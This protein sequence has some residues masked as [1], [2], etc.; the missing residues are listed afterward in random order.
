LPY[1]TDIDTVRKIVKNVGQA[2]MEDEEFGPDL[3][4]A[5]KSQGVKG[6]ADSVMNFGVKFTAKP[7]TQFVIRRELY[8]RINEALEKKGIKY[9]HRKVIVDV[10][11]RVSF[12][13][14]SDDAQAE[15]SSRKSESSES[16][17]LPLNSALKAAGAAALDTILKDE[18]ANQQSKK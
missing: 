10:E 9:A 6:I 2:M 13:D 7:G 5:P 11:Q 3:I 4:K 8:K 16:S 1:D 18:A 15:D 17:D 14:Q 12:A